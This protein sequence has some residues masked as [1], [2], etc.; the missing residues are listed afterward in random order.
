MYSDKE[1]GSKV[2]TTVLE[3]T[4][5]DTKGDIAKEE[6]TKVNAIIKDTEADQESENDLDSDLVIDDDIIP[7]IEKKQEITEG[8]STKKEEPLISAAPVA[9]KNDNTSVSLVNELKDASKVTPGPTGF[10]AF[11]FSAGNGTAFGKGSSSTVNG[12]ST[13][14]GFAAA[15][16]GKGNSS[17][18]SSSGFSF[19]GNATGGFKR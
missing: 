12:A 19:G 15:G 16:F 17:S 4:V 7:T 2:N 10:G 5:K 9:D 3:N 11:T 14:F 1:D 8:T 6:I 18:F 13:S